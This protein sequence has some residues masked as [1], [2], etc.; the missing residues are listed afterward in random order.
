MDLAKKVSSA[1]M[2]KFD[3]LSTIGARLTANEDFS[4]AL[5]GNLAMSP[6]TV[7]SAP[8]D[9]ETANRIYSNALSSINN[10]TAGAKLGFSPSKGIDMNISTDFD[11][12]LANAIKSV[13]DKEMA[14]V[15]EEAMKKVQDQLGSS[16]GAQKYLS[17]F[18]DISS[19]INASNKSMD[20]ISSEL[21][22]KKKE[23]EKKAASA[24]T[25][26]AKD[27]ASS[28]LKGLIKK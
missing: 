28:A 4:F 26:A 8:L 1:G 22:A 10:L 21:Q 19:K 7:S 6:V 15:K 13:A 14:N 23:L 5:N 20:L 11:R 16:D 25:G 18:S 3:G 9:G 17:Q 12:L 27:K 24:A 2:P